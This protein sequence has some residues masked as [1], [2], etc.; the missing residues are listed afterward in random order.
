VWNRGKAGDNIKRLPIVTILQGFDEWFGLAR[1]I[2]R[3]TNDM[4]NCIQVTMGHTKEILILMLMTKISNHF[5]SIILL[6]HKGLSV[7]SDILVRSMLES[8]IPMKLLVIEDGF[9]DE[10]IRNNPY[11]A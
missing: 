9:F 1:E 8:V 11:S 7:E 6:L 10:F 5:Q 2:N 4:R 3:L